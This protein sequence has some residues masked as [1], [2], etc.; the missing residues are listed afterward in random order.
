MA[1]WTGYDWYQAEKEGREILAGLLAFERAKLKNCPFKRPLCRPKRK[2]NY[3]PNKQ[4]VEI[5]R[6]PIDIRRMP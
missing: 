3:D 6:E 4:S 5:I 1:V 2:Y